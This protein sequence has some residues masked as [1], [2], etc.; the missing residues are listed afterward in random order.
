MKRRMEEENRFAVSVLPGRL[1]RS[2]QTS[3]RQ[4]CGTKRRTPPDEVVGQLMADA[5]RN[6]DSALEHADY[7]RRTLS[8]AE[9]E[10]DFLRQ[11]AARLEKG[12]APGPVF[13]D[14]V[15]PDW[16]PPRDPAPGVAR[17]TK[18]SRDR[19]I[20]TGLTAPQAFQLELGCLLRLNAAEAGSGMRHFPQLLSCDAD[21]V[22]FEMTHAGADLPGLVKDGMVLVIPD[23]GQQVEVLFSRMEAMQVVHLD[24]HRSGKNIAVNPEGT[25]SLF[26]FDIAVLDGIPFSGEIEQRL[27]VFHEKGGY[28]AQKDSMLR[29]LS[30]CP[31]LRLVRG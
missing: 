24:I 1:A 6:I 14:Q 23:A 19:L 22:S 13:A 17:I 3:G 12:Q 7:I 27:A 4:G 15:P 28:A 30:A 8:A 5:K 26:D 21:M 11:H 10:L 16:A 20:L 18:T 2:L 9:R 31:A 29:I 25:I